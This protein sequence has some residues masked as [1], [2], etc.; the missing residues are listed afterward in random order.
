MPRLGERGLS[1]LERSRGILCMFSLVLGGV[2]ESG[3]VLIVLMCR[4]APAT[5]EDGVMRCDRARVQS[6]HHF[7]SEVW[8]LDILVGSMNKGC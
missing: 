2:E 8:K 6:V 3:V 1:S 7:T 4:S 5:R